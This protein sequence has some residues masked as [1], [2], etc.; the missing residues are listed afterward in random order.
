MLASWQ[1]L[2]DTTTEEHAEA[3]VW[4]QQVTLSN[5]AYFYMNILSVAEF[6]SKREQFDRKRLPWIIAQVVR[7]INEGLNHASTTLH[8]GVILAVGRIALHD[9]VLGNY[10]AGSTI[11]RPAQARMLAMVGGIENVGLPPLILK[12]VL[13]AD[14]IMT[15]RTGVSIDQLESSA[16]RPSLLEPERQEDEV[17]L[18]SYG[19]TT[20]T[21]ERSERDD[22][23]KPWT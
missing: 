16:I 15:Q 4:V 9:I 2:P 6:F 20:P 19:A 10:E 22:R 21:S 17:V 8:A 14:R 1:H 7:S 5:P 18:A 23:Q 11:H 13:W 3:M 12:H